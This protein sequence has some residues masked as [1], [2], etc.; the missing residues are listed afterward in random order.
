MQHFTTVKCLCLCFI[1]FIIDV[2]WILSFKYDTYFATPPRLL[3]F[4]FIIM[5]VESISDPL[6]SLGA[7]NIS[8]RLK[9]LN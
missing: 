8:E 5:T 3:V 4:S 2:I 9:L 6:A 7:E 1:Y